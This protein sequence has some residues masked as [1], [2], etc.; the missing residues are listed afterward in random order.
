M[1]QKEDDWLKNP[2]DLSQHAQ[3]IPQKDEKG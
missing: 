2:K 1:S 3:S